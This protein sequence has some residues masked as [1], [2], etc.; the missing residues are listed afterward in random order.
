MHGETHREEFRED[1][2]FWDKKL[3]NLKTTKFKYW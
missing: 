1:F 2:E 3:I